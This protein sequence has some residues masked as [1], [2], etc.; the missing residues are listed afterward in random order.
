M[1]LYN[2]AAAFTEFARGTALADI[3]AALAIPFDQLKN[4][5]R[6]EGW[7]A[8]ASNLQTAIVP[9]KKTDRDLAKIEAN[10]EKNLAI[11][12]KLQQDLSNLVDKLI[13]DELTYDVMTAKGEVVTIKPG[14]KDRKILS[15][16]ALNVATMTYRALGD[17]EKASAADA[18]G[19]SQG[20]PTLI[21]INLPAPVAAARADRGDTPQT[22]D[23]TALKTANLRIVD[24]SNPAPVSGQ[25][26]G[27]EQESPAII[28]VSASPA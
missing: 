26:V 27:K 24:V 21:Q 7:S 12:Q 1:A 18:P 23:V 16:Y 22:V 8:L 15:E 19:A 10:R 4:K 20:G 13:N 2:Y 3:S 9:V 25:G 17:V 28:E 5:S 14:I 11:A 6:L